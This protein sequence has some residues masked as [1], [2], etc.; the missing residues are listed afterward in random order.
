MLVA[1]DVALYLIVGCCEVYLVFFAS[2]IAWWTAGEEYLS[3]AVS[4]AIC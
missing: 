4:L 1:L 3:V 2:I